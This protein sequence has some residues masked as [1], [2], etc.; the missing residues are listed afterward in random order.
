[1]AARPIRPQSPF[2]ALLQR[3]RGVLGHGTLLSAPWLTA[4]LPTSRV[5]C[6][7]CR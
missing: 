1:L 5:A 4:A 2:W 7:G 3:V 6:S